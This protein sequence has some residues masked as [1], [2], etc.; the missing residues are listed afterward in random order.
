MSGLSFDTK[1]LYKVGEKVGKNVT[2]VTVNDSNQI[3]D[4]LFLIHV[5]TF[6]VFMNCAFFFSVYS[7]E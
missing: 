1:I 4:L 2:D 7:Q 3:Q 5:Y 6:Q